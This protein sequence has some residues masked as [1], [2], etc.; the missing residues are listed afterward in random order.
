MHS[1]ELPRHEPVHTPSHVT[2]ASPPWENPPSRH[3]L[4]SFMSSTRWLKI[5]TTIFSA[6]RSIQCVGTCQWSFLS[7][8]VETNLL[9]IATPWMLHA[10][11]LIFTGYIYLY[12]YSADKRGQ[13]RSWQLGEERR[14][15]LH[16]AFQTGGTPLTE[17]VQWWTTADALPHINSRQLDYRKDANY[18]IFHLKNKKNTI[19][20]GGGGR[21]SRSFPSAAFLNIFLAQ[22]RNSQ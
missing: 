4:T 22:T 5:F 7:F 17:T 20:I 19:S 9:G 2:H 10:S 14:E 3:F 13:A 12:Y 15:H 11:T 8:I 21:I 16:F 1:K 18:P 6:L